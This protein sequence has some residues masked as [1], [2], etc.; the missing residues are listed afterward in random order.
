MCD[1]SFFRIVV[2]CIELQPTSRA[3]LSLS[4][5]LSLFHTHTHTQTYPQPS[6]LD[7]TNVPCLQIPNTRNAV[8]AERV[9]VVAIVLESVKDAVDNGLVMNDDVVV[10]PFEVPMCIQS[11]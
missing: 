3:P 9:P 8:I 11:V 5:S 2:L 10:H 1:F 6:A 4:L 7:Y